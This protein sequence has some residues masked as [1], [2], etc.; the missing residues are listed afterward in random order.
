MAFQVT[1]MVLNTSFAGVPCLLG[2][3]VSAGTGP[4][5]WDVLWQSGVLALDVPEAGLIDF[6]APVA[7]SMRQAVRVAAAGISP[8]PDAVGMVIAQNA[9]TVVIRTPGG[10]QYALPLAS[11]RYLD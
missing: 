4:G 5:E 9:T 8:S 6:V 11:V 3:I 10:Y 7:P 1:E 2:S